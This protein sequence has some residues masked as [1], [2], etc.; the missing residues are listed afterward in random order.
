MLA[1]PGRRVRQRTR[2]PC[3]ST[4]NA[5]DI[6]RTEGLS[7][8]QIWVTPYGLGSVPFHIRH[9]ASSTDRLITYLEGKQLF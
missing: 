8:V 7:T 3:L 1:S 4:G 5:R 6:A 9:I 2:S